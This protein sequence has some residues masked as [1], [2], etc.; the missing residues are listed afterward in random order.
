M[1]LLNK[2]EEKI[3]ETKDIMTDPSGHGPAFTH[4]LGYRRGLEWAQE[5]IKENTE[6]RPWGNFE[7]LYDGED[8]K[9]KR[10]TVNPEQR[11][12]YQFHNKRTEQWTIISGQG[13]VTIDDKK[14]TAKA[15]TVIWIPQEAKHRIK[16][17]SKE[18][19][20]VFIETQLGT[21]FGEDD[22]TRIEDDYERCT[23]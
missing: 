2:I 11:L 22:I 4:S 3:Q 23:D 20:L 16:N 17:T 5:K 7:V 1:K 14:N 9:V 10:I 18:E 8:C 6:Q 21:Y 19:D 13:M 15:G 12:S